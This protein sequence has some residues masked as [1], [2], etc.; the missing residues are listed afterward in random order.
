M[1]REFEFVTVDVFTTVDS[2]AI[3]S[4]FFPMQGA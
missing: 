1:L 4:P 3:S 2:A